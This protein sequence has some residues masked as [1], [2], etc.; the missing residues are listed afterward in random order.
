MTEARKYPLQPKASKL[1]CTPSR[2]C[3]GAVAARWACRTAPCRRPA[4]AAQVL[5]GGAGCCGAGGAD[6]CAEAKQPLANTYPGVEGIAH[7]QDRAC[8][9]CPSSFLACRPANHSAS[10][11]RLFVVTFVSLLLCISLHTHV[12]I[13]VPG[14]SMWKASSI[15]SRSLHYPQKRCRSVTTEIV[16]YM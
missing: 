7:W 11:W 2:A 14:Q 4:A 15:H 16:Y 3:H 1:P 10:A 8:C 12:Q 13:A 6:A 9:S 5:A